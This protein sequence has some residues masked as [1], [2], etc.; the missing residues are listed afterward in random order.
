MVLIGACEGLHYAHG[1]CDD[2][3]ASLNI[4]HRD[5]T[6]DNVLVSTSGV[7]KIVDFGIAK[8][9]SRATQTRTGTLKGKYAY[10]PPEQIR[11]EGLDRRVD[12]Y[13]MGIGFYEM[14]AGTRPFHGNT[15]VSLLK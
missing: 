8:A 7:P 3:G 6:P 10:M 4:I 11:G 15:E 1:L 9:S 14:L 12:V 5:V 13:S 2:H